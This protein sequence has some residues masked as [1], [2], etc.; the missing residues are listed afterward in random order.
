ML[1]KVGFREVSTIKLGIGGGG[2]AEDDS[3]FLHPFSSRKAGPNE[4]RDRASENESL[5]SSDRYPQETLSSSDRTRWIWSSPVKTNTSIVDLGDAGMI[6][7]IASG[8]RI[9]MGGDIGA[10]ARFLELN[11][12]ILSIELAK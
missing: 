4:L 11:V 9:G 10:T 2:G 3:Q 12:F 6:T 8:F 7:S 1:S 5:A